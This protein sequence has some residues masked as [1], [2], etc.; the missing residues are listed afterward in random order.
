M[1]ITSTHKMLTAVLQPSRALGRTRART[2]MVERI[3][4]CS[5]AAGEALAQVDT[6][7]VREQ[8]AVQ[9]FGQGLKQA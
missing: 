3:S 9:L 8:L 6:R 7:E 2:W 5:A 4:K 1:M